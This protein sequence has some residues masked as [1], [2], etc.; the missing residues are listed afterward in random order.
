MLNNKITESAHI[1]NLLNER[2]TAKE[3]IIE[4]HVKTIS[5]LELKVATS[6]KANEE[7][8]RST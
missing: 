5:D 6:I 3:L 7:I 2:N 4:D 1:Q 8:E